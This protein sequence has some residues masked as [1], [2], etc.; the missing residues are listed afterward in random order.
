VVV[1]K[2][3]DLVSELPP[4]RLTLMSWVKD[5]SHVLEFGTATGYMTRYL[6]QV[7]G[8]RVTGFE[9]SP[10]AAELAA[11]Y[12]EQIIVGDIE[13]AS[14]WDQLSSSYDAIMLGDVLEHL[15]DPASVMVRCHNL[16]SQNG[17]LI[18][19]VP[20]IAHWTIRWDLLWGKFNY[21]ETGLLDNTH[22]HFFTEQSFREMIKQTGYEIEKIETS[23]Y[24]YPGDRFWPKYRLTRI[25]K[26]RV[27][28]NNHHLFFNKMFPKAVAWQYLACCRRQTV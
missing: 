10:E 24:A 22:V 15:R 28:K 1:D 3:Y 18:I 2:I 16:L 4:C 12:C 21:T 9:Y 23:K 14:L 27:L 20:N 17:R 19:S 13:D 11:A 7:K 5:G 8:C 25:I 26:K 6:S